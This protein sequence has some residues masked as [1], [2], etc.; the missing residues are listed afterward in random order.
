MVARKWITLTAV[1]AAAALATLV[2]VSIARRADIELVG[3]HSGIRPLSQG[4]SEG[5]D[6]FANDWDGWLRKVT[7]QVKAAVDLAKG[8]PAAKK[9][10]LDGILAH[11]VV[12]ASIKVPNI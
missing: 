10:R 12:S 9:E 3:A 4:G 1:T 5:G 8:L 2:C 11:D 7:L 6:V